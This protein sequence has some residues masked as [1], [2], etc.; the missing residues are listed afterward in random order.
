MISWRRTWLRFLK[1]TANSVRRMSASGQK[2]TWRLQLAMSALPPKADS[3]SYAPNIR[4]GPEA[5]IAAYSISSLARDRSELG[6]V[7]PSALAVL[8][9][10]TNSNLVA[11]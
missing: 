1:V 7:R 6:T 10:I 11:A 5:D 2:R 3:R 8:R 4:F 9:L